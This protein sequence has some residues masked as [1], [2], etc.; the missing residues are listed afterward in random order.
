M[1][2]S[3]NVTGVFLRR[4]KKPDSDKPMVPVTGKAE[5]GGPLRSG[6]RA[7]QGDMRPWLLIKGRERGRE[8]EVSDRTGK[9]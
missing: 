2:S 1:G 3:Y 6:V 8:T 4:G 5:A 9:V 7:R